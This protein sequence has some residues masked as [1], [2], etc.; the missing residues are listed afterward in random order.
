MPTKKE[1][2]FDVQAFLESVG[3]GKRITSYSRMG[4]IFSQGDPCDSV[5]YLR[6]GGVRVS[7]LSH[8]GKE[9][10]VATLGPG[11]FLG[12]GAIAGH[13]VRLETARATMASTVLVIPKR[14]MLRLLQTEH[15]FSDRFIIHMLVRNARLEADL[16]DQLFNPSEKRLARTLLLLARYGKANTSQ[17]VLPTVSQE[18]L[19]EMIERPGPA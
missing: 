9:A 15:T 18:T 6:S 2:P 10:I 16:V 4:V 5:M 12:E 8:V 19:T 13:P 17:R 1:R 7:V 11:D 14:Q 3:I